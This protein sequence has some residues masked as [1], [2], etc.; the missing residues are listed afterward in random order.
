M[1]GMDQRLKQE[2]DV[3][4]VRHAADEQGHRPLLGNAV[5]APESDAIAGGE[6]ARLWRLPEDIVGA[7][8]GHHRPDSGEDGEIGD[9]VHIA[10]VLSHALD[11][12]ASERN[13]VPD[14]SEIAL[15][16]LGL[17]W[18]MLAP[19]FPEI[20]ARYSGVRQALGL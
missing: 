18:S 19:R 7:I 5:L 8:H 13:H 3:L 11:L 12:G 14:V 9:L 20:E 1:A 10:E 16:R 17:D 4:L 2:A 15:L 6:L